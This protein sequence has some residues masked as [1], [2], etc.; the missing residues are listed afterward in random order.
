MHE[1]RTTDP[2]LKDA[3]ARSRVWATGLAL[4]SSL[5]LGAF[6]YTRAHAAPPAGTPIVSTA[7][8]TAV[9]PGSG[10]TL[11]ATSNTVI[12]IVQPLER[13]LVGPDRGLSALP[14]ASVQFA[15]R[16]QNAGNA[17]ADVQLDAI[18][19]P[20]DDFALT[21]ISL[22][23][24]RDRDGLVSALDAVIPPGGSIALAAGDSADVLL[25]ATVPLT[26]PPNAASLLRLAALTRAQGVTASATDTV[27]TPVL[28][29]PP[30]LAFYTSAAYNRLARSI[31]IGS[32]L[33]VQALAPD[34]D[35]NSASPDTIEI[36]LTSTRT[37]DEEH[38]IAI[39]TGPGTGAFRFQGG[40]PSVS[41][42]GT[43]AQI[44][45]GVMTTL[46]GDRI[47][48]L[49]RGCGAAETRASIWVE[50]GG[51]VFDSRSDA[52]VAGARVQLIDETGAGN[53]GIAGGPARVWL[54]DGLTPAPSEA[55]TT[56]DGRFTFANVGASVYRLV[57]TPP[58]THRFPSLVP[59]GELPAMRALDAAGSF[60]LPFAVA[61]G[62]DPV[63]LDVPLDRLATV[64]LFAEKRALRSEVEPGD[65]LDYEL[66]VA[67]RSDS[68]QVLTLTDQLPPGFSYAR[69]TSVLGG[70]PLA[71]PA[72]GRGPALSF[73][74]G[75]LPAGEV[76]TLRYR[77]LV[78][79][80]APRGEA[81]NEA[82][83]VSGSVRSNTARASVRV[84]GDA[85]S[86]DALITGVVWFAP[87]VD[88]KSAELAAE[89]PG[90]VARGP[91]LSGVRVVL[92]DGTWAITDDQG[93]FRFTA[94]A[95]RTHA[96]KL[97]PST[98]PPGARALPLTHRERGT[99]G[100]Q[101]VDLMRGGMQRVEFAVWG[102]TTA[103]RQVQDRR[104][105]AGPRRDELGR[106]LVRAT[107]ATA[108]GRP[109]GDLRSLPASRVV[110]GESALPVWA[111]RAQP[112]APPFA[113]LI[114]AS[115]AQMDPG[116]LEAILPGL[117]P[118][119]GFI[120]LAD[121]DTV[122]QAQIAVRV[123]GRIG[124]PL[125]LRVNGESVPESRV[126]RRLTAARVGLEAWEYLGITLQPGLNVLE[127]APPRSVGRVAVRLVAPG[128]LSR[129][130]I[131]APRRAPANGHGVTW[132]QLLLSDGSGVPVGA[133]TLV[134]LETDRGRIEA[135][136]LDPTTAGV[137]V[138]VEGGRLAVALVSPSQSGDARVQAAA[139]E[140]RAW[141]DVEFV[142]ELR[143]LLAVGSLE[144]VV[145]LTDILRRGSAVRR[146]PRT[147]FE[148]PIEQWSSV[149]RDGRAGAEARGALYLKG[150]ISEGVQLTLGYDSDRP[151]DQRVFRDMDTQRGYLVTGDASVVGYDAQSA[152][153]LYARLE[154]RDASLLYGDLVTGGESGPSLTR[155]AR[156]LTGAEARYG[157]G[158]TRVTAFTSRQ[159][160]RRA[161]EELPG[162]GIS[163]PYPLSR[164]PIVPNSER[165]ELVVRDRSQ[166]AVVLRATLQQRFVDYELDPL[167]GSLVFRMPIASLDASFDPV[168]IRVSYEVEDGGEP[169]WVHGVEA[170][171][172]VSDRLTLGGVYVDDHDPARIYSLRGVSAQIALAPRTRLETEWAASRGLDAPR[173]SGTHRS[174]D[175]GRFE[176]SHEQAD[177]RLRAWGAASATGFENAGASIG[178]G[179]RE[180][181]LRF[182]RRLADR[183]RFM[184]EA[185]HSG[186][187]RGSEQRTG[188]LV[189]LDRTLTD[190]T[191]GE[192]GVRV[193]DAS[194]QGQPHEDMLVALRA[195]LAAQWPRHP[196][197]SGYL[198]GEQ[199]VR[200]SGRRLAA[201]GGEYR[202]HARGRLHARHEL[203][204]SLGSAFA[205]TGGAQRLAT[206]VGVEAE[207]GRDA[208][209]F[210]EYRLA[211]AVAGRDAQA[212]VGLR[213]GWRLENGMRVGTS[214]ERVHPIAGLSLAQGPNTAL[215]G[216][217]DWSE[218]PIWKGSAR[219]EVRTSRASDQFLQSMAAA[220]RLDSNWTALGRHLLTLTDAR[221]AGDEARERL[222]LSFAYRPASASWDALMRYE[223]RYD[224]EAPEPALRHRRLANIVSLH[225]A[226]QVAPRT[227]A[228]LA[229]AGK[230]TRDQGAR[231]ITAGGA[232]WLRLRLTRDLARDWDVAGTAS[233]LTGRRLSQ[234]EGGVGL[235]LGRQLPGGVWLSGGWNLYGYTDD[236]LSGE[237]WTRQGGFLRIRARVDESLIHRLRGGRP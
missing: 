101:A 1:A 12:A 70:S 231:A 219:M 220:V 6:L 136:D 197:W 128:A 161:I 37:G 180:A 190:W 177:W 144:G 98:L 39:E 16:V 202:F 163:G 61:T 152:G 27:R 100:L 123:K 82:V 217:V 64:A 55:V 74:L 66:R 232:Q 106:A 156:T 225:G 218:D 149:S 75:T 59:F 85:F 24:D 234:R 157:E 127:V 78:G 15:H 160:S 73:A 20:G 222:G 166:P 32:L 17:L 237:E 134:T 79:P 233:L 110:T 90:R 205:L 126:G 11:T 139:G 69:G 67:N 200:E 210:S 122:T 31:S 58:A 13:L 22:V 88:A 121:M 191:R 87:H 36:E 228:S 203:S 56:A 209:L 129:L 108:E 146:V 145:S 162:R 94:I 148:Q 52:P 44:D 81:I 112:G 141:A 105:A 91:G 95:G 117:E 216:S 171:V 50:P 198:E 207:V 229:W 150:R 114:E 89:A 76:A 9:D 195:K 201:V 221:G 183:T 194:R 155:Y 97:D 159:R 60:G 165:V 107:D 54:E 204:S 47:V 170:R 178:A 143:P 133:R 57:V 226:A 206:V 186:D 14:G 213:N 173:E 51:M 230:L 5:L 2:R 71:D 138:A 181:G 102:D 235:E 53:G 62:G 168:S 158:R 192:L 19:L 142:P 184:A 214:F 124:T 196:E 25:L 42:L 118:D 199:D 99:P 153:R 179:R 175:A 227:Q 46:P 185:L 4:V 109:V 164:S 40:A 176:L 7:T 92:D 113:S 140:L 103:A 211:D 169:A 188:A 28:T 23:H 132:L 236:E 154:R 96:I 147:G 26:A 174:G 10:A 119:L 38:F 115:P 3:P 65:L 83:A 63:V 130:A 223:F 208:H 86:D 167:T 80:G 189:S 224:R 8:G 182:S 33:H 187:V 43:A 93:R 131:V 72:G 77:V 212:A 41:A 116:A 215:T 172:P 125:R 35:R 48:A 120:G 84:R 34:C 135:D 193:A 104:L 137:Q 111:P 18:D 151:E 45:D 30:T 21:A 68:A 29:T 49:L